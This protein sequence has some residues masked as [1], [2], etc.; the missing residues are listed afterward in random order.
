MA[1]VVTY[2]PRYAALQVLLDRLA[3]QVAHTVVIDN[4]PPAERRPHPSARGKEVLIAQPDNLGIGAAHNA[5]IAHARA[6]GATHVLLMDQ[7]S[8]PPEHLVAH[9]LAALDTAAQPGITAAGPVCQDVKTGRSTLLIQRFGLR[10]RRVCADG[11][12]EP[13]PVEYLPASG[14]LI[15]LAM[16]ERVGPMR[17][18]YFIDRVDVEWCLR[19]RKLG[20]TVLAAPSAVMQHD[21]GQRAFRCLG[22]TMYVGRD[23]RAYFHVRNSLAMSLRACIPWV[24]R[25]DQWVKIVPYALL[26]LLQPEHGRLR[27]AGLLCRAVWDGVWAHMGRGVFTNRPLR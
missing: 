4:T 2:H 14:M 6:L 23:F 21:L 17:A 13:L 1:V 9:L 12:V 7:D 22:R 25:L 26:Y 20:F 24:W 3:P 5:G 19:A 8:L 15:P 18:E 27:M 11:W 16:W 10:I